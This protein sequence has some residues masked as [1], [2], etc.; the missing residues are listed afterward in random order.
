MGHAADEWPDPVV[1]KRFD[2]KKS[3]DGVHWSAD[4]S[5]LVA[6]GGF[7][8]KVFDANTWEETYSFVDKNRSGAPPLATSHTK[9]C[10]WHAAFLYGML[11]SRS[12]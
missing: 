1:I 2:F 4:G 12:E 6:H 3:C 11:L 5:T 9:Q 8:A 7:G 10:Y